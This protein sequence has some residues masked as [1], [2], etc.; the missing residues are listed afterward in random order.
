MICLLQILTELESSEKLL[1]YF[2]QLKQRGF[3]VISP[4]VPVSA[5]QCSHTWPNT[6]F[7]SNSA[8]LRNFLQNSV[9]KT[10]FWVIFMNIG[11]LLNF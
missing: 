9:K 5:E 7:G 4:Y 10:E 11:V 1:I 6:D 3:T 8:N 2:F